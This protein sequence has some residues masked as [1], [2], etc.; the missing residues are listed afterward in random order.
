MLQLD[1]NI[2]VPIQSDP[3]AFPNGIP[4]LEMGVDYLKFDS[5]NLDDT[6]A[7]VEHSR[8]RNALNATGR[9][10]L[11]SLCGMVRIIGEQHMISNIDFVRIY[12]IRYLILDF[13][14]LLL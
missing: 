11:F 6:P 14:S 8:M 2:K 5:C 12:Y 4:A 7:E 9:S 3:L 1:I 13:P 10:I